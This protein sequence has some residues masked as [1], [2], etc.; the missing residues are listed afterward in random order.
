M[1]TNLLLISVGLASLMSLTGCKVDDI[2]YDQLNKGTLIAK[3]DGLSYTS[4]EVEAR[5]EPL[6]GT[7]AEGI[8]IVG[9]AASNSSNPNIA[10]LI[11]AKA[12]GTFTLGTGS[13]T[14]AAATYT[15]ENAHVALSISGTVTV[16]SISYKQGGT[17]KGTFS[18]TAKDTPRNITYVITEGVF[19]G[20]FKN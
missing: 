6:F 14:V 13:S 18:F 15:D 9:Y 2:L 16:S 3:I 4:V 19:E 10:L 20:K 17:V 12:P 7:V 11:P 8:S 5:R 1:K